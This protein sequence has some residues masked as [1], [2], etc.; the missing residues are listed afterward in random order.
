MRTRKFGRQHAAA[1]SVGGTHV[2]STANDTGFVRT[3][4]VLSPPDRCLHQINRI[5]I[6]RLTMKTTCKN[7]GLVSCGKGLSATTDFNS[8]LEITT[9]PG[10]T[11]E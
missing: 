9:T 5:R 3:A 2:Q 4:L 1:E 6:D 8:P 11:L 7:F 10:V